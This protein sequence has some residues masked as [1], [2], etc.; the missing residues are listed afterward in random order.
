VRAIFCQKFQQIKN[1]GA[2]PAKALP[3]RSTGGVFDD[4]DDGSQLFQAR[5]TAGMA[6][7]D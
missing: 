3:Y 6:A 7:G 5:S 4:S 2:T 1:S